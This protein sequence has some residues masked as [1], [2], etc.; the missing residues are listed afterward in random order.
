MTMIRYDLNFVRLVKITNMTIK[1]VSKDSDRAV[2]SVIGV[3][4]M[5]AVTVIL[6]ASIGTFVLG[7]G[8]N[9]D[10]NQP[11][12]NLDIDVDD[13]SEHEMTIEHMGGDTLRLSEFEIQ[14][15]DG[16]EE[17]ESASLPD[18]IAEDESTLEVGDSVT[19]PYSSGSD[20]TDNVRLIHTPS[21]SIFIDEIV[22]IEAFDGLDEV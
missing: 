22:P 2:S 17:S 18:A 6:A 12:A 20:P 7:L 14:V 21:N 4:L 11:S 1:S 9:Q 10:D 5:V 19:V 13:S 15:R 3:V 8:D 16:D